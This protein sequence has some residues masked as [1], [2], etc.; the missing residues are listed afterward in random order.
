MID[1]TKNISSHVMRKQDLAATSNWLLSEVN[2]RKAKLDDLYLASPETS[3]QRNPS[4]VFSSI[5]VAIDDYALFSGSKPPGLQDLIAAII[6]GEE[7]GVRLVIAEDNALIP[8]DELTRR[9]KQYACG[10]AFGG[11]E[12]LVTFNITRP[13]HGQKTANLPP[14]RGYLVKRGQ[15]ELIQ[16]A[17]YWKR[18]EDPFDSLRRRLVKS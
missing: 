1:N 7:V 3:Y 9:A 17:T 2:K 5:V 8:S 14:G 10:L 16:A 11:S 18:D 12:G 13:P 6:E 15:A 4:S